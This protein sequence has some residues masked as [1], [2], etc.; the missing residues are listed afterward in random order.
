[1]AHESTSALRRRLA[2]VPVV[3]VSGVATLVLTCV[4]AAVSREGLAVIEGADVV[5][6]QLAFSSEAFAD[7]LRKWGPGGIE[8]FRAML[9]ID[10][11]YAASYSVFLSSLLAILTRRLAAAAG[12]IGL[13]V[14]L[15]PL[16]AA[17]SDWIENTFHLLML[18]DPARLSET[19]VLLASMFAAV[20][21]GLV[22]VSIALI[23]YH[24]GVK[25][26]RLV[27]KSKP[28]G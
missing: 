6:L 7:V 21:W 17:A 25:L 27:A 5:R 15:A 20:K 1:M 18:A 10:Y 3:L 19:A 26:A 24:S 2:S 28:C 4:M 9:W 23:V 22:A 16:V 13:S 12:V 11:L 14:V 8:R